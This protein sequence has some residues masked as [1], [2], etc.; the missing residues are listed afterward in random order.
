MSCL[1]LLQSAGHIFVLIFSF[2]P[3]TFADIYLFVDCGTILFVVL[4]LFLL[5]LVVVCL[6][7]VGVCFIQL[8]HYLL[9]TRKYIYKL[10]L[11]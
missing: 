9:Y 10:Q 8:I 4:L 5:L 7:I 1:L 2:P 6:V 11:Y 3:S